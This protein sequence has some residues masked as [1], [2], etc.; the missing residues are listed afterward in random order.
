M[1]LNY[2]NRL[3]EQVLC[4]VFF[5]S[6]TPQQNEN[7]MI[8]RRRQHCFWNSIPR[9]SHNIMSI[10]RRRQQHQLFPRCSQWSH[11]AVRDPTPQSK[12]FV[13]LAAVK[14]VPRCR[15]KHESLAA[16]TGMIPTPPSL[17]ESHAAV[18]VGSLVKCFP[19]IFGFGIGIVF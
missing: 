17:L 2:Q 14:Y 6:P 1:R 12:R 5:G 9:S 18:K 16:V 3:Q 8:P 13:S 11:A 19:L 10:P 7:S 15:H 4:D